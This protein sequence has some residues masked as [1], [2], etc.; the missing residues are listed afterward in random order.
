MR[1]SYIKNG[2]SLELNTDACIGCGA[3]VEVCPHAV[4]AM[5]G[6]KARI[7]ERSSCMECGACAKNCPTG[8]ISVKS[9]VG[10]AAAIINGILRG[11]E[12][13]CGCGE[14]TCSR[15]QDKAAPSCGCGGGGDGTGRRGAKKRKSACCG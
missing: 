8:A 4:F 14:D 3:C 6:G 7:L 9:G 10:C 12:A 5:E 15:G 2:E 11:T 1:W 13:S